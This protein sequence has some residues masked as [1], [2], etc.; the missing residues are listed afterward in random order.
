[1]LWSLFSFKMG[2][3]LTHFQRWGVVI[4][5]KAILYMFVR[6]LMASGPKHLNCLMFMPSDSVELL[7]VPFKMANCTCVKV[8]CISSMRGLDCMV[9]VPIGFVC[10]IWSDLCELFIKSF[11]SVYVTAVFVQKQMFM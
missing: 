10:A 7:F 9:Y 1:M 11:Y 3:I 5:L 6:Y 4:V 2:M 8:S